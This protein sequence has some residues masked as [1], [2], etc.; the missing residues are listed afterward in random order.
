MKLWIARDESGDLYLYA[1][2]PV[3]NVNTGNFVLEKRSHIRPFTMLKL[4]N[5]YFPNV[6]A[7]EKPKELIVT[8]RYECENNIE[9]GGENG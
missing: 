3:F 7:G 8:L 4:R 5:G 1:K 2:C 9:K 6:K